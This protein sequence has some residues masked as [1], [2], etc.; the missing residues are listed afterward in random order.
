MAIARS[1]YQRPKGKRRGWLLTGIIA[2]A[3]VAVF[4]WWLYHKISNLTGGSQNPHVIDEKEPPLKAASNEARRRWPEFVELYRNKDFGQKFFVKAKFSEGHAAEWL[5]VQ[6]NLIDG[7]A[8]KNGDTINGMVDT[9]PQRL[10]TLF[11]GSAVSPK[12]ENVGDWMVIR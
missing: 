9:P 1:V 11:A 12:V 8:G 10:G 6:V 3:L 7:I 2:A 4:A 5:W